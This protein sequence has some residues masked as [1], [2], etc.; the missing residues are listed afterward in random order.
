MSRNFHAPVS[1]LPDHRALT[2]ALSER[3]GPVSVSGCVDSQWVHFASELAGEK[4]RVLILTYNEVRAKEVSEDAQTFFKQPVSFYPAKDLLFYQADVQGNLLT[5]RRMSVLKQLLSGSPLTVVTTVDALLDRISDPAT[6]RKSAV[7]LRPGDSCDLS[8]LDRRLTALGYERLPEVTSPGEFAR[9]GDILDV[10]PLSEEYPVRIEFWGD[11]I[12]SVRSFDPDTQRSVENLGEAVLFAASETFGTA[13]GLLDYFSAG[14]LIILDEPGRIREKA[15]GVA[16]EFQESMLHRLE[17]MQERGESFA[18]VP[19]LR[20]PAELWKA[21]DRGGV[22]LFT[23]LEYRDDPLTACFHYPLN[24]R[25]M[26]SYGGHFDLLIQDLQK[27]RREKYRIIL[28]S[29]SR[30]R[31]E[32]LAR[33][34]AENGLLSFYAESPDKDVLPEQIL[35]TYG[36]IHKSFEYPALRLAVVSEGDLFGRAKKKRRASSAKGVRPGSISDLNV[37]DYVIHEDHGLGIYQGIE[38]KVINQI[39]KDFLKISYRDGGNLYVPVTQMN[40]IQKY[41]SADA[42]HPPVLNRLDGQEW[43]KTKTR[44]RRATYEIAKDLV[45][46][47]AARQNSTG[48]VYGPDTV[49]QREF[50]EQFPYEETEDQLKAIE[51]VKKDMESPKIMDRLI[52]GDVGFGK[53]EIAIRAAFKA[54]QESRQV[55][56]LVPTTILAQQH[57]NTFVSRM[58]EYPVSVELLSRFRSPVQ[59]KKTV[60]GLKKGRVDIVIGT[61]RLLSKDVNFKNLGLLI[62]DEE[63]RFGVADKEKIKKLRE[64][65]DVMSLTATPIPRTLHMSLIGIRDMSLLEE[66]PMDRVAIQ[67]YVAQFNTEIV[68]E[69]IARELA[70]GGQVYYVSNQV[71]NIEEVTAKVRALVP[72]AEVAYAHGQMKER[73]LEQIMFDFINGDIDVLVSTTIIETGLD[74]PN[75]N[76]IIIQD[77]DRFGLAQLYQLRGRVGRS[78]RTAY[79]FL[80]YQG[81]KLLK[82]VAEKRLTAIRDFTELGSGVRIS[83]RDLE[84]RGAGNLLGAEQHGHMEAVGYDLYCKMLGQA[85]REVKGEAEEFTFET[86]VDL[87]MD[88]NIPSDYIPNENQKMDIYRRISF[89]RSRREYEDMQDELIDRFGDIPRSLQHLLRIALLRGLAHEAYVTELTG[90]QNRITAVLLKEAPLDPQKVLALARG[91]KGAM[92]LRAGDSPALVL[93]LRPGEAPT[94]DALLAKADELIERIL[95]MNTEKDGLP[96]ALSLEKS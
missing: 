19:E 78:N 92:K 28:L 13:A 22:L 53:T 56:Y 93:T 9:R 89:I 33:D 16:R 71:R 67:T 27:K 37:G 14:D 42:D 5:R 43:Q 54:V 18:S 45:E 75:V 60:E 76:T 83:M 68:R 4:T 61:H 49:W 46:L 7:S 62:I 80:F 91:Y 70:R 59:Q 24:V 50:E 86:S 2:R 77:A 48:Y 36:N 58:Q 21:L 35:V 81:G 66:P 26:P 1:D 65:V 63:Q 55:A 17:L 64:T 57:Y 69:A 40:R 74:I 23:G 90:D 25:S 52:C 44:V 72:D 79:A 3:K 39:E 10:Y 84:I 47:Y 8:E 95:A 34:L 30:S 20:E 38:K 88:A 73:E 6:L 15:E 11:E 12:D 29:G 32:R 82:D 85:V 31:A 94:A 96:A 41:A 51:A 87:A